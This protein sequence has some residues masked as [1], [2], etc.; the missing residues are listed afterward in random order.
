MTQGSNLRL[1]HWQVGSF[2]IEPPGKPR[3]LSRLFFFVLS[4]T[5]TGG[6]LILES[7]STWQKGREESAF[8]PNKGKLIKWSKYVHLSKVIPECENEQIS[9]GLLLIPWTLCKQN[10]AQQ[11]NELSLSWVTATQQDRAVSS[12][13]TVWARFHQASGWPAELQP[14][15]EV[16]QPTRT[17]W[18]L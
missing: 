15:D 10:P 16:L 11:T 1:L 4:Q 5:R 7:E 17:G 18:A 3:Y 8:P 6:R 2:I 9:T 14:V 12:L 13:F